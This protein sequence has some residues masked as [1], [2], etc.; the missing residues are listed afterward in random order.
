MICKAVPY[1]G[2][3]PYIF[4]SYSHQDAARVYPLLEQMARD[5]YR[6]WY[7][8]GNHPGD[9]WPENIARHLSDC[10]VC[11]AMLSAHAGDSHNCRN[12]MNF[13]LSNGK[14]LMAV[15]LEEFHMSLGMRLQLST[16]HYLK[17][18]EFSDD[19]QLRQRL[20]DTEEMKACQGDPTKVQWRQAGPQRKQED[21]KAAREAEEK[22]LAEEQAEEERRRRH[23]DTSDDSGTVIDLDDGEHTIIDPGSGDN[24]ITGED[25][26]CTVRAVPS[27][28]MLL[29]RLSKRQAFV[30]N[31]SEVRIGRS[32]RKCDVALSDNQ[33]ISGLHAKILQF[34]GHVH[35]KD[36]DSTNGTFVG[37]EQLEK[38]GVAEL[39]NP[40]VFRLFDEPFVLI[41]GNAQLRAAQEMGG[42]GLLMKPGTSML[43]VLDSRVMLGRHHAWEDGTMNEPRISRDHAEITW[44][45]S[46]FCLRDLSANGTWINGSRMTKQETRELTDGDKIKMGDTVLDFVFV[47]I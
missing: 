24:T 26:D 22:R 19:G 27:K 34:E 16:I 7:D 14:K 12:E 29:L 32:D 9:N 39:G 3:E 28:P 45:G 25:E 30:R 47:S 21:N 44:N 36:N 17:R 37:D 35:L 11:L 23:W 1:E 38:N 46:R 20:Y 18:Y 31:S 8:D 42:V 13:A 33:S 5:G 10:T 4:F 43:R 2:K 6:I 41:V 40:A 15:M